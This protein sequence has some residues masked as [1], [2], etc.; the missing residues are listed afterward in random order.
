VQ[1]V[2]HCSDDETLPH[3]EESTAASAKL[4]EELVGHR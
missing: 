4:I 2:L 3:A 1:I